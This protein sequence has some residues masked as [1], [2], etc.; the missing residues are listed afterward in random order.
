MTFGRRFI[1]ALILDANTYEEIEADKSALSQAVAVI[2]ITSL[3]AAIGGGLL[4]QPL[5]LVRELLAPLLGWIMFAAL[6]YLIG[7]RLLPMPETRSNMGE[8]L[9]VIGFSYAPKIFAFIA[10]VPAI[11]VAVRTVIDFW[12]LA[13]TVLAVRQALDYTSTLRAFVVVLA[14]WLLNVLIT[15]L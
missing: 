14:G 10:F 4:F 3:A 5:L 7:T 9:R 13:T 8:L 2:A 6:T 11:G 1:G 12:Q 15:E